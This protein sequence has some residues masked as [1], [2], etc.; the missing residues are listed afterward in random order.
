[1]MNM[2]TEVLMRQPSYKY[3]EM[4]AIKKKIQRAFVPDLRCYKTFIFVDSI[5]D[6]VLIEGHAMNL[7]TQDIYTA[8]EYIPR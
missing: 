4:W 7:Y 6:I 5:R 1:M 8:P 3:E 2:C